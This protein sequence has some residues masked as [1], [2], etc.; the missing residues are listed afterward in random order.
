MNEIIS[1]VVTG[2]LVGF[3]G[4][5]AGIGGA[6]LMI[7]FMTLVLGFSQLRAQG[8]VLT[9]MLGPMSLLGLVPLRREVRALWKHITIGVLTYAI[10]S[11]VG[12]VFAFHLAEERLRLLFGGFLILIACIEFFLPDRS[13]EEQ[14]MTLPPLWVAIVGILTGV[15]GGLFGIGAGVLMVPIFMH[16]FHLKKDY[17]RALS[18]AILTPPVSIGAF[19]K[20][21]SEG[22]VD[23]SLSLILFLAY[24]LSNYFG[25]VLGTKV[26]SF[27]FRR[28]YAVIL[29]LL[30]TSY[31]L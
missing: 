5:F 2:V 1:L 4:G 14:R 28:I 27:S 10:F 22:M 30:G 21:V 18:L 25:S 13:A 19:V 11:Y 16:L 7:A 31:L 20:Y 6:P 15:V 17:A 8:I 9:M 23:I 3:L 24:F 26:K 12:A 29:F